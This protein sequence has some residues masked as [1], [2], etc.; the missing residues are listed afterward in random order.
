MQLPRELSHN[1]LQT[2][3]LGLFLCSLGGV[4]FH[5]LCV[6]SYHHIFTRYLLLQFG[7]LL[8]VSGIRVPRTLLTLN[9]PLLNL[10]QLTFL[11]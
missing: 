4:L 9:Q 5:V 3:Q 7:G 10:V 1:L 6:L 11:I 2:C 8:P